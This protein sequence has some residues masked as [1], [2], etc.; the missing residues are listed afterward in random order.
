M[1]LRRTWVVSNTR[2]VK[3]ILTIDLKDGGKLKK[4]LLRPLYGV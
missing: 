4:N 3:K 1:S 2:F